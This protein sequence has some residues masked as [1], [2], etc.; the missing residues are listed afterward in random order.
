[1]KIFTRIL[2]TVSIATG[3]Y[4]ISTR[5]QVN[6]DRPFPIWVSDHVFH[7]ATDPKVLYY[8]PKTLIRKSPVDLETLSGRLRGR[9]TVGMDMV[10]FQFAK[11]TATSR[12]G[13]LA[14][15]I[16]R[17]LE[18]EVIPRSGTDLPER[19]RPELSVLGDWDLAGPTPVAL[20]VD[21]HYHLIGRDGGKKLFDQVFLSSG[22]DHVAILRYSFNAIVQ[23]K[24]VTARTAVAIFA[25]ERPY[26]GNGGYSSLLEQHEAVLP[27]I[28]NDRDNCWES[29][30]PG[31][32]C[33]RE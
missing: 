11:T 33:I 1:M 14:V 25:G 2:L 31:D 10:D 24:P 17:P 26:A 20:E 29:V 30:A 15:R 7:S 16:L 28:Q 18:A 3:L 19:F 12:D 8:F 21:R 22:R 9:F 13:S 27:K 6:L 4:P 32:F 23:G 5:A